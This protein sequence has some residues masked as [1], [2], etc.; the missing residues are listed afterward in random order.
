[1]QGE[2]NAGCPQCG[3]ANPGEEA[4]CGV[5]E[6]A[7]PAR[8][9]HAVHPHFEPMPGEQ[10]CRKLHGFG[11]STLWTLPAK[12]LLRAGQ[13]AA[14]F[15]FSP[16]KTF[17]LFRREGG[18]SRPIVFT[19]LLGGPCLLLDFALKPLVGGESTRPST[20][21]ALALIFL[22]PPVYV[23]LRAH[24]LHLILV[25]QGRA[26]ASFKT[27]FR[28]AA[29]SNGSL[30]PLLLV[31]YAGEFLF[32]AVGAAVEA[33][34]LRSCHG[35]SLPAAVLAEVAPYLLLLIGCA[36]GILSGGLWW[37]QTR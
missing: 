16:G 23:Y 3:T 22:A 2:K 20:A 10:D 15:A 14:A 33:L 13:T 19:V 34:G 37:S 24:A 26:R 6:A 27:T 25:L 18:I 35:L 4:R 11:L 32:L 12:S 21:T 9:A 8:E 1:M 30:A 7:L 17:Q 5:C 28:V 31:P 36:A 29:Y